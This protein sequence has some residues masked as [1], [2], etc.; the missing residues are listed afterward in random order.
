MNEAGGKRYAGS[1][2]L[3]H[4]ERPGT[5]VHFALNQLT[6]RNAIAF[7]QKLTCYIIQTDETN[8]PFL[9]LRQQC[10]EQIDFYHAFDLGVSRQHIELSRAQP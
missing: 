1:G 2:G 10:A 8:I 7:A 6:D 5:A 3:L 4:R 9:R